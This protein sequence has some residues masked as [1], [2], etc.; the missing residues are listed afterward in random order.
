MRVSIVRLMKMRA[1]QTIS[2]I[3]SNVI[4]F[5]NTTKPMLTLEDCIENTE[6]TRKLAIMDIKI[7][8]GIDLIEY[9]AESWNIRD[10]YTFHNGRCTVVEYKEKVPECDI[11]LGQANLNTSI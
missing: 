1:N 9:K 7:Q 10:I 8:F 2:F 5:Q 11:K 6:D 3:S 4:S